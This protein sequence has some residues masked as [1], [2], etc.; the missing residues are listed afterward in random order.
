MSRTIVI[1]TMKLIVKTLLLMR[2]DPVHFLSLPVFLEDT[3]HLEYAKNASR[4]E[5]SRFI[6]KQETPGACADLDF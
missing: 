1:R 2:K 5:N 6:P 4:C 3:F